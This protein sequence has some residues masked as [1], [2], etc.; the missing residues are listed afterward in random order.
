MNILVIGSGGREHALCWKL[1]QS[2]RVKDIYCAPGN[3]GTASL[4]INVDLKI[5]DHKTVIK[6][7]KEKGIELVIVGPEVPLAM[8]ITD[9]LE[10]GGIK[11]FGP[12]YAASRMESS[13]IFAKELMGGYDIP[14]AAFRIFDDFKKAKEHI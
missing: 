9:D 7:C 3:G 11:V 2:K 10:A 1:K 5:V 14:T 6:F 12:S 13:K 4:V 8:G